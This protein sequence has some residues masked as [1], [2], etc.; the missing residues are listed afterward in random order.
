MGGLLPSIPEPLRMIA[1]NRHLF[2]FS[3]D[4][5]ISYVL[6]QKITRPPSIPPDLSLESYT[7]L[8]TGATSGVGLEASRQFLQLRARLIL[9]VRNVG[10]GEQ[11]KHALLQDVPGGTVDVLELDLQSFKSVEDFMVA[12]GK[13]VD[14]V[15]IAVMNAGLFTRTEQLT[16]DGY[17]ML[18]Q[19]STADPRH[20]D[21]ILRSPTTGQFFKH[22]IPLASSA[23]PP[24]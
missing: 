8:V 17:H 6:R 22:R 1:C 16:P 4:G 11:V 9:G 10:K 12:L 18:L 20:A 13:L 3:S 15:D 14:S 2:D 19:V 7:I 24:Q 23:A 21:A 5:P